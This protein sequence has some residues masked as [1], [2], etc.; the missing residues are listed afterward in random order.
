MSSPSNEP[1]RGM[2]LRTDPT[3][4][5]TYG[6][7]FESEHL[8]VHYFVDR[9]GPQVLVQSYWGYKRTSQPVGIAIICPREA[10]D[11]MLAAA[12]RETS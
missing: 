6:T 2:S 3:S 10:W 12:Q 9:Q 11:R 7:A 8:A 5:S 4:G 1:Q